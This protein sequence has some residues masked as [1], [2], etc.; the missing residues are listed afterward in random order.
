MRSSRPKASSFIGNRQDGEGD[1]WL[2]L[3]E[4]SDEAACPP[5]EPR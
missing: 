3:A 1:I 2:M 5:A 4:P